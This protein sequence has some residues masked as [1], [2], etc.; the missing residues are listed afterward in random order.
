[1]AILQVSRITNRKGLTEN[2]PQL[3][4]AE[5]GWCFDS[6]RLFIGNGTLQ[7][8]APIIGNTEILTEYSDITVLSD[9]T[10]EDIIVGYPAQTGVTIST[11][12]I[13]SVQA[14]LDDYVSVRAF[15]AVGDGQ[16]DDTAAINRA[17]FQ[18]YCVAANTEIRRTLFFPAG[19]YRVT[20]SIVI[21]A[22]AKLTGE[23]A[24]CSIILLDTAQP[25]ASNNTYVARYGDSL[26]QTGANIGN[27]GAAAPRNIE[28]SSMTF[29]SAN[30][31]DV[32]LVESAEQCYFDSVD[33]IGPLTENNIIEDLSATDIAGIRFDSSNTD[34]CN[35]ITFDKC[36]F[37]GLTYAINTNERIQ[38]VTVSNSKFNTLYQGVVLGDGAVVAGGPQGVRVQNSI[39][40]RVFR[41]GIVY[42]NVNTCVSANNIFFNVGNDFTTSPTV[43][44]IL[45]GN[46]NNVSVS[47]MFER[48]LDEVLVHPRV[49]ILGVGSST[50]TLIQLGR[51]TR[52]SG[53]TFNLADN[54]SVQPV[55]QISTTLTRAF[56]MNYTIVRA[57]AVRHGTLTVT[58]QSYFNDEYTENFDTGVTLSVS[59]VDT[60]VTVSYSTTSVGQAAV[61]TYSIFNLA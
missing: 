3:A 32:F 47:D 8:G 10:Y 51:Y 55:F 43:S 45:F 15:G 39:F 9:Y 35:Q 24:N 28:I 57:T 1:M 36:Q 59:T 29:Q 60:V 44:I 54:Q 16:A 31:R 34:I 37:A 25:L 48:T 21:P 61:L 23:G 49:R 17:L 42:E 53:R 4:G 2:L 38:S 50:G 19:T 6:R 40:D 5:L 52:N 41:E 26:Q 22:Y 33:F 12:V 46:D 14:R 13:R 11:P 56:T 58:A 18:L 20:T 27:N 30:I 7:E